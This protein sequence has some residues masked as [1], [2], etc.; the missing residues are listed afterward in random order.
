MTKGGKSTA[1]PKRRFPEF[2]DGKGWKRALL[3]KLFSD[4]QETGFV[5]LPLLS[6]MDKEGIVR[7]DETNRKNNS[8]ADRSK[9]LRVV[10][11]D[12]AYNTMRMWEGRSAYV[13]LEGLVSPAY[14]VCVPADDVNSPYKATRTV[15]V[16]NIF[17]DEFSKPAALMNSS[18]LVMM[19]KSTNEVVTHGIDP[20]QYSFFAR[21]GVP[22]VVVS[23]SS[24]SGASFHSGSSRNSGKRRRGRF[25]P[26]RGKSLCISPRLCAFSASTF[27]RWAAIT[28]SSDV[29]QSAIFCCSGINGD[30]TAIREN[31]SYFKFSLPSRAFAAGTWRCVP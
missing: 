28:S 14:T 7:Q 23:K 24:P 13:G 16:G 15:P 10:P 11:G 3:G 31:A 21:S 4:R 22:P 2:R 26:A 5:D 19:L 6:L 8:S 30:A 20:F 17:A 9:Y 27:R 1:M 18:A 29:R 12:I 25:S